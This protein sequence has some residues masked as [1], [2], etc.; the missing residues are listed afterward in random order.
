[1]ILACLNLFWSATKMKNTAKTFKKALPC[2]L[3]LG[4]TAL[5]VLAPF[6]GL[7]T[8]YAQ[9]GFP[10]SYNA[11]QQ[12]TDFV[13]V[14][15]LQPFTLSAIGGIYNERVYQPND[16]TIEFVE[17]YAYPVFVDNSPVFEQTFYLEDGGSSVDLKATYDQVNFRLFSTTDFLNRQYAFYGVDI[18]NNIPLYLN[19]YLYSYFFVDNSNPFGV[20]FSLSSEYQNRLHLRAENSFTFAKFVDN[21]YTTES[22]KNEYFS[23]TAK[24]LRSGDIF[25][26]WEYLEENGFVVDGYVYLENFNYRVYVVVDRYTAHYIGVTVQKKPVDSQAGLAVTEFKNYQNTGNE[27]YKNYVLIPVDDIG[28][29]VITNA[30]GAFLNMEFIPNF[31]LWYFLLIGLG[32]AITGIALKFFLG[33]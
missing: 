4:V 8:A 21:S 30:V 9:Q 15:P 5:A 6:T 14:Y 25:P 33:G 10:P 1:M 13:S 22:V 23:N 20:Y 31:K 32:C 29:G 19:E 7:K 12:S 16:Y 26:T 3:G 18:A 17:Q 11:N 24:V 27:L 2:M 28:L